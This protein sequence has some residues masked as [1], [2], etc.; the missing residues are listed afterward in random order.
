MRWCGSRRSIAT[1]CLCEI[2]NKVQIRKHSTSGIRLLL[3]RASPVHRRRRAGRDINLR[4]TESLH[5]RGT[6]DPSTGTT[7]RPKKRRTKDRT[8]LKVHSPEAR[9]TK[10]CVKPNAV[11]LTADN[12]HEDY[13]PQ[14]W[15]D[16]NTAVT[17]P[18][19]ATMF[20]TSRV[21]RSG[22]GRPK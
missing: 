8:Q 12:A 5:C 16:D 18:R 20:T 1:E 3:R 17:S 2:G 10:E 7:A 4:R 19:A 11:S 21:R 22:F 9:I 13:R 6:A 15:N 14:K